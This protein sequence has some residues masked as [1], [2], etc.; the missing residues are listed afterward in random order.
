MDLQAKAGRPRLA[1][2]RREDLDRL[3]ELIA[4][5]VERLEDA[6]FKK[7][8]CPSV[9]RLGAAM[10]REAKLRNPFDLRRA[11][12]MRRRQH[13]P[14]RLGRAIV[15]RDPPGV[16][17]ELQP[18]DTIFSRLHEGGFEREGPADGAGE[19]LGK[20]LVGKGVHLGHGAENP[21]QGCDIHARPLTQEGAV[22]TADAMNVE[23]RLWS[24]L[25]YTSRCV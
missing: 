1:V 11:S 3:G 25:L 14:E 17:A 21:V 10:P 13:A 12:L 9:D 22:A 5:E 24:C 2:D 8:A 23:I 19:H 4:G 16:L 18:R 6:K 15:K 7:G 20:L